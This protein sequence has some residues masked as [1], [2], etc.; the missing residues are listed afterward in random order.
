MWGALVIDSWPPAT[1]TSYSPARTSIAACV[2][3]L[4]PDRQSLLIV[5]A[6]TVIGMPA[7]TADWRAGPCPSPAWS[8]CPMITCWTWSGL[9]PARVSAPL[10]SFSSQ[11]DG[12]ERAQ[13]SR[14]LPEWGA[15]PRDDDGFGHCSSS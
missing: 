4:I 3:A 13:R 14:H 7:F 11:V 8:T 10:I 1:T 6:L 2:I 12:T 9:T 5:I 15:R